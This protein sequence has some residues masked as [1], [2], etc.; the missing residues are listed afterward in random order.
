MIASGFSWFH[1][2]P[3]VDHDT[4]LNGIGIHS[5][6]FVFFGA[7]FACAVVL[8]FAFMARRGI[9]KARAKGGLEQFYADD[10]LSARNL[11]ELVYSFVEDFMSS[12]LDRKDMRIFFTFVASL[13][14]YIFVANIMAI[15]PGFQPPTDNVNTNVGMAII[16]FL[17]FN[18]VGLKR[19]AVGYIKHLFG[20]VIF[21]A[22]LMFLIELVGLFVRPLS[23][24][25]RLTGN[26]YGDHSV[27]NIMSELA[28][29][30]V[31]AIFLLLACLVS[32][33]QAFVFSLL[34]TV[35]ISLSLPHGEHDDH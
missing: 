22:P 4:I 9:M 14:L 11:A 21:I 33:I 32:L 2:I 19:D 13:F 15:V 30:I 16:V 26:I 23:L 3:G 24:T 6:T 27:F 5:E 17:V 31:P 25:L 8:L 7:W 29:P 35:Y 1:L 20:P 12:V 18:F 28:P 10:K 34:T